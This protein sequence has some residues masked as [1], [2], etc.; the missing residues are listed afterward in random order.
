MELS[1]FLAQLLGLLIAIFAAAAL[2][3]PQ[4]VSKV[5][6]DFR[7]DSFLTLIVA[8]ISIV[9]GLAIILSHNI[10]EPSWRIIITI[11]GWGAL[12]KGISYIVAPDML[13]R[14]GKKILGNS[15]QL[16]II[17][18]IDLFVGL[19]LAYIGFGI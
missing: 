6:E 13:L 1:Y 15:S 8:F 2:Y 7:K 3:R 11:I 17:L 19:Y 10:W 9:S 5:L 4:L 16:K 18:I 12:L 14:Y